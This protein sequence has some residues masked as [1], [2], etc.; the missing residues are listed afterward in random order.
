M[1]ARPRSAGCHAP[2]STNCGAGGSY[3]SG[4]TSTTPIIQAFVVNKTANIWRRAA[5]LPGTGALNSGGNA[6]I[7]AV[8]CPAP[9]D[10][11]AGRY[12]T[13]SAGHQ[14][15]M[16]ATETGG[17]WGDAEEVPGSAALNV[18]A[19][20]AVILSLWCSGPG[21][22]S[23]AGG[24][25]SDSAGHE[26]ALVVTETGGTWG[27][28]EEIPGTGALNAGGAARVLSMSCSAAGDCGV[29][30]SYASATVDGIA[31]VQAFVVSETSGTWGKA[32][33]VPG[34]A[35]LNG[36]GYA[37]VNSVSCPSAGDCSAGGSYTTSKPVT[38]AFVVG[39]TGGTWGK[40]QVVPGS[41]T[42]NKS[43]LAQ[44]NSVSCPSAR[45][46]TAD[47]FYMDASFNTQ[48]FA[49]S[50]SGGTWG[51]AEEI[52]GTAALDAGSPGAMAVT[53]S[54]GAAG[55][56]SARGSYTDS[57]GKQQAFVAHQSGGTWGTAEEVPGTAALNGGS[58]AIAQSVSC[59]PA[60]LCNAVG[61][62]QNVK[63]NTQVYAASQS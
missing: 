49:V 60:G 26:Q 4:F 12:Y 7:N 50:E 32:E 54:C 37:T 57:S 59:A 6:K 55:D 47:G 42:L 3:A 23:S 52:P 38:Q 1:A 14:Q 27:N 31:T 29:G 48:A 17:T 24:Y 8:S 13:D 51:T 53:V 5:E 39:E 63:L 58:A 45:D 61:T 56:C 18:G 34:T 62:Y 19:P 28:A 30:G 36:G 41:A 46:C 2:P 9:G 25:Y 33:E 15:A 35:A 21:D 11:S 40:A 16:V 10:C 22:C 44:V 43:G 20:G